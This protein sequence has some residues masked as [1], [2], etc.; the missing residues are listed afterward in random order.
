VKENDPS[1]VIVDEQHIEGEQLSESTLADEQGKLLVGVFGKLT[2]VV[3]DINTI[4]E[5]L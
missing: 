1:I 5:L 2:S 3:F 4:C